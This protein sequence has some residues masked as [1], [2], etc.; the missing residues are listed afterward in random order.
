MFRGGF[1]GGPPDRNRGWSRGKS[2][3]HRNSR[4]FGR[5][6]DTEEQSTND[7]ERRERP[8]RERPPPGLRG[9]AIGMW[10][11]ARSK[12][13]KEKGEHYDVFELG[14]ST[15]QD[16]QHNLGHIFERNSC[17]RAESVTSKFMESYRR[18]LKRNELQFDKNIFANASSSDFE[19]EFKVDKEKLEAQ[20][21]FPFRKKLP[22]YEKRD[23]ISKLIES[24]QVVVISGE[25][26]RCGHFSMFKLHMRPL[27]NVTNL[28]V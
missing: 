9:R 21:L 13:R 26:G 5:K 17:F 23:E 8:V 24:N 12:A 18:N 10:Y 16:I 19:L 28:C 7:N 3:G 1:R 25:T 20:P 14:D 11:A 4:T 6:H 15:V 2:R 22:A 27:F